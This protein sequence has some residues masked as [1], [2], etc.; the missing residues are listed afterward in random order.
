MALYANPPEGGSLL[1]L[2]LHA[3]SDTMDVQAV[4]STAMTL[5]SA[6]GGGTTL[7]NMFNTYRI[8]SF[9]ETQQFLVIFLITTLV[10]LYAIN[11][12]YRKIASQEQ[13]TRIAS[14][15]QTTRIASE[16][17]IQHR[18]M[19][20]EERIAQMQNEMELEKTRMITQ[21]Q[22]ET[23]LEKTRMEHNY[24]LLRAQLDRNPQLDPTSALQLAANSALGD[25]P[26]LKFPKTRS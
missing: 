26:T 11:I 10:G 1:V 2:D 12:K 23:E 14:Q 3:S 20:S 15:E 25:G 19:E 13:I 21:M 4:T 24:R 17:R 22:N 18:K 6:A 16:E 9:L 7:S 8:T 5:W